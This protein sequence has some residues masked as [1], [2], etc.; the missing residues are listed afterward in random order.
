[1]IQYMR[2]QH[3]RIFTL[4]QYFIYA[5]IAGLLLS[6]CTDSGSMKKQ[7]GENMANAYSTNGRVLTVY[8]TAENTDLRLT[9]TDTLLFEQDGQATESE[10]TIFV[11]PTKKFQTFLGI[12]A[13]LTDASAETYAKLPQEKRNEVI[14]KF[15]DTQ[16]GIGY[17]LART[18]IASC[19]FSSSSFSYLQAND[20][21]LQT[22]SIDHDMQYRIPFIKDVIAAAGGK[23]TLYASP[24]SPP[25][26]MKDNNDVLHGGK[27]LPAFFKA[28]AMHYVKFIQAYAQAGVPVW[29]I[30]VQNEPMA[31]QRWES[32]IYTAEEERDFIKNYLGPA[33]HDAGFQDKKIIA[34]DHNRDLLYQRT[35]A[36]LS[37][38]EAAKYIWGIGLHW[39][40]SWNGGGKIFDNVRRVHE[41]FPE[42]HLL[43]TEGCVESYDS[44]RVREW[45]Y[46]EIYGSN[47]IQD[48]NNGVVGWTDW[49]IFLDETGGPN[50]VQNFCFAPMHANTK[51]GELIFLNSYYYI[52]HFSKFIRPG[53]QRIISSSSN[54]KLLT[55]AFENTDGS[56]AVVVMNSSDNNLHYRIQINGVAAATESLPH[57]IQT[58]FI[59]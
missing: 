54:G 46:G 58:I 31:K 55:T 42:T 26:W 12:G 44:S 33:M 43:F 9:L 18:S 13:A 41:A 10:T 7:A 34:W 37:D 53:A 24:W 27:L 38:P 14:T 5:G 3:I 29:G 21:L 51:T 11:D 8:S 45:R 25:A 23:L 2:M 15:F 56:I 19:D 1:M 6:A 57:S 4:S 35:D 48:F 36:V 50:H 40:E 32:C 52:G 17:S 30:T 28:W 39:Y 59:Q 49:N 47:M 20:T 16:N 22:F